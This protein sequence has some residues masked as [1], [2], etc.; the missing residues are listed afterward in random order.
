MRLARALSRLSGSDGYHFLE[1]Q[2]G[3]LNGH[4][5]EGQIAHSLVTKYFE[6]YGYFKLANHLLSGGG[7]CFDVGA[8]FGFHSFG[9]EGFTKPGYEF[10]LFEPNPICCRSIRRTLD[11]YSL[12][13]RHLVATGVGDAPGQAFLQF[14]KGINVQGWLTT[15]SRDINAKGSPVAVQTLDNYCLEKVIKD[16]RLVKMDIEGSELHALSGAGNLFKA[17]SVD[18]CYF[19]VN[20]IALARRGV[21]LDNLFNFFI[22]K[23]YILCWPHT[24]TSWIQPRLLPCSEIQTVSYIC[25]DRARLV[26]AKFEP[27]MLS[28]QG[29]HQFDLLAI[30]PRLQLVS[31]AIQEY[32]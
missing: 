6:D 4:I 10:H 18:F 27:E 8:N 25:A 20:Q 31:S 9:L 21:S 5:S 26:F 24:K 30:S 29:D 12:S 32:D 23:D 13:N 19:E 11:A 15:P 17:A 28:L 16:V 2:S 14:N 22:D 1:F 7:V 3:Y